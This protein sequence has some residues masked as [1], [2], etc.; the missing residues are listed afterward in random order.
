M[1]ASAQNLLADLRFPDDLLQVFRDN[2]KCGITLYELVSTSFEDF[3][4]KLESTSVQWKY[5]VLFD[6]ID[7]WRKR[8]KLNVVQTAPKPLTA[9][10]YLAPVPRSIP[11]TGSIVINNET[12]EELQAKTEVVEVVD[13]CSHSAQ[14]AVCLSYVPPVAASDEFTVAGVSEELAECSNFSP[15]SCLKDK[16]TA[17]APKLT[18]AENGEC[19]VQAGV[20]GYLG[21]HSQSLPQATVPVAPISSVTES[22][23]EDKPVA[24]L[25]VATQSS[26]FSA[27]TLLTLLEATIEGK[28]IIE[29]AKIGELSEPKQLQLS[30][31]IAK[32]HLQ[33]KSRL[34]TEDLETYAEAITILF[35]FLEKGQLLGRGGDRRNHAGKIANKIANLKHKT[36][37]T[38]IKEHEHAKSLKLCAVHQP[39]EEPEA[40]DAVNWLILNQ[41]TWDSVLHKWPL[42]F[43][44][45]KQYLKSAS[46]VERL[47]T[48]YSHYKSAHGY[49][50]IDIDYR[51]LKVGATDGID[52]LDSITPAIVTY[53]ARKGTDPS[54]VKLVKHLTNSSTNKD[55]KLCALLLG[56]STVLPPLIVGRRFKPTIYMA[57]HDT[58]LFVE[59]I[60]EITAKVQETYASYAERKIAVVPKLVVL[61]TGIDNIEGRFFVCFSDVC[62]ELPSIARATDVL[63][64]LSVV[65]GFLVDLYLEHIKEYHRV[66]VVYR[67][68]CTGPLCR[69]V[70]SKFYPFKKH[71]MLHSVPHQKEKSTISDI[72]IDE[73]RNYYNAHCST[74]PKKQKCGETTEYAENIEITDK[75]DAVD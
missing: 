43:N 42:S 75:R 45:R 68:E 63:I 21:K 59:S 53:I 62:Y 64:K 12:P 60:E 51:L 38:E 11:V 6:I 14:S 20:S 4:N 27:S 61:G 24:E 69:L 73:D 9:S 5:E 30:T 33:H 16:Q 23:T 36:R 66:P 1:A 17:E 47:L 18:S 58:I 3:K 56:L 25:D 41:H 31:T 2:S 52:K 46:L 40:Q 49:Q 37:K 15:D 67:Y 71:L 57:Q 19:L 50:L 13:T 48:T 7:G 10:A 22:G 8:N 55:V 29:K 74:S 72:P 65:F 39:H 26:V 28:D 70:F 34:R 54:V 44:H 32:F 35:K